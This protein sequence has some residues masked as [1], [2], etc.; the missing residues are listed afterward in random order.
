MQ[1]YRILH[2]VIVSYSHFSATI[3]ESNFSQ[4]MLD[5]KLNKKTITFLVTFSIHMACA[6]PDW[7]LALCM[8]AFFDCMDKLMDAGPKKYIDKLQQLQF[9]GIKIIYQYH[10]EGRRIKNTDEALLRST[11]GLMSM[12]LGVRNICNR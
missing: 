3:R 1:S 10:I 2:I 6:Q 12:S 4:V 8:W 11:L 9:R 7:G 5:N